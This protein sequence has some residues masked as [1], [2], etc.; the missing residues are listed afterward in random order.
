MIL[1]ETNGTVN[2]LKPSDAR[3][4]PRWLARNHVHYHLPQDTTLY[5]AFT[6]DLNYVG[7]CVI[8][9]TQNPT[10]DILWL[11]ILLAPAKSIYIKGQVIWTSINGKEKK[12]GIRFKY[13][14]DP[15]RNLIYEH[16]FEINKSDMVNKWF[17]GWTSI[18]E[19]VS[20]EIKTPEVPD[21]QTN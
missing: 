16:A 13:I 8:T 1:P 21:D 14:S 5:S 10:S 3:Y 11:K 17:N 20:T 4:L 9:D 12:L 6:K 7:T 15:D 2:N 19:S 18:G